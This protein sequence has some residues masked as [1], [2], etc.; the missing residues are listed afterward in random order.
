MRIAAGL[1]ACVLVGLAAAAVATERAGVPAEGP[2]SCPASHPIKGYAS[3][4]SGRRVYFVPTDP[5]YDEASPERCY[6][7][8]DE[9]RHDGSRPAG[10]PTPLLAPVELTP[11]EGGQLT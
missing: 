1:G 8:E 4:E 11:A 7:S 6:A 10:S 9:A 3:A 5:Y 2:W